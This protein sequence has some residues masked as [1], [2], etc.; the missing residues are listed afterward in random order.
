MYTKWDKVKSA[1]NNL[2]KISININ[3]CIC[4]LMSVPYTHYTKEDSVI[5]ITLKNA[6]Q[7]MGLEPALTLTYTS[8]M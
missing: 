2:A 3:R 7:S 1:V 6:I 8:P 5:G 4:F